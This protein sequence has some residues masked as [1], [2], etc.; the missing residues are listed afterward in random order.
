MARRG[1]QREEVA[2][3]DDTGFDDGDVSIAS[4]APSSSASH[5]VSST[6]HDSHAVSSAW[7]AV[8]STFSH[9]HAHSNSNSI[10]SSSS[11]RS[12]EVD[13]EEDPVAPITRLSG[14][15]FH[16]SGGPLTAGKVA[17]PDDDNFVD[18]G[19]AIKIEDDWVDPAR[20]QPQEVILGEEQQVQD[21]LEESGTRADQDGPPAPASP[22][23]QEWDKER[24]RNVTVSPR[25]VAA[26]GKRMH[27]ARARDGGRTQSGAVHGVLTED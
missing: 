23:Q 13:T 16:L 19:G 18:A 9:T 4:H 6:S 14:A 17:Y 22:Q 5:A 8:A 1:R 2:D 27:T 20:A 25:P 26:S 21:P 12:E 15:H 3:A 7:H 24:Q 10:T 11:A